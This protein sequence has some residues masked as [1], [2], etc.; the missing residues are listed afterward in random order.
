MYWNE[1]VINCYSF[2]NLMKVLVEKWIVALMNAFSEWKIC[3][4]SM[5][6]TKFMLSSIIFGNKLLSNQQITFYSVHV[7]SILILH[8]RG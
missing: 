6:I 3:F 2:I 7:C 1:K 4:C 5:Y 8:V